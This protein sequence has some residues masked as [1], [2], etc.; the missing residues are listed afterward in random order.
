MDATATSLQRHAALD[1]RLVAAVRD[2][3][4]LESVSWP[5]RAQEEFLAAWH[6]GRMIESWIWCHWLETLSH[7]AHR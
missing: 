3:R 6:I 2:I 5:A 4:L 1:A 7:P